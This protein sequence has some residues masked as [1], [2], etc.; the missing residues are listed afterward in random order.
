MILTLFFTSKHSPYY[1]ELIL[2][3]QLTKYGYDLQE[4]YS[5][6]P[7]LL[8]LLLDLSSKRFELVLMDSISTVEECLPQIP[9]RA[10]DPFLKQQQTYVGLCDPITMEPC[11]LIEANHAYENSPMSMSTVFVAIP[12]DRSATECATLARTI[13]A[14]KAVVQTVRSCF[15]ICPPLGDERW[16]SHDMH[17]PYHSI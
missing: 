10:T 13:L 15:S 1:F 7:D 8:V 12:K 2:F 3:H 9:L 14:T 6:R 16:C 17:R 11:Q 5:I 4:W